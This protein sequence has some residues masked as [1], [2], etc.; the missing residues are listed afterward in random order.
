[1][2][3]A[4]LGTAW[5]SYQSAA[6]TRRSNRLM[7]EVQQRSSAKPASRA[8]RECRRRRSMSPCSCRRWR[9]SRPETTAFA[10]FLRPAVSRRDAQRP[11]MHGLRRSRSRIR[12]HL[13]TRSCRSFTKCA[14]RRRRRRRTADAAGNSAAGAQLRRPFQDNIWRTRSSSPRC[15]SLP[16]RPR[17]SSSAASALSRSSSRS[18]S[19]SLPSRRIVDA[20]ALMAAERRITNAAPEKVGEQSRHDEEEDAGRKPAHQDPG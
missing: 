15:S 10:N 3:L 17:N 8:C 6:W 14:A 1:M 18:A 5:C 2:A 16:T 11:T 20:A 13:R 7:N 4:T 12:T 9:R 19:S